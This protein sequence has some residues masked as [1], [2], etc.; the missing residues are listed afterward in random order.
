VFLDCS[1]VF[2]VYLID[3]VR[4]LFDFSQELDSSVTRSVRLF[5]IDNCVLGFA[6]A[7]PTKSVDASAPCSVLSFVVL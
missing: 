2:E 1:D 3:F 5:R 7:N 4:I 6:H